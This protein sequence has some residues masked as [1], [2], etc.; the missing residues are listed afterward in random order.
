MFLEK[1]DTLSETLG[2]EYT[3]GRKNIQGQLS[4]KNICHVWE[5][6]GDVFKTTDILSVPFQAH[7]FCP[8]TIVIFLDLTQPKMM[9][10]TLESCVQN[11]K[12]VIEKQGISNRSSADRINEIQNKDGA[13]PLSMIII[14]GKYELFN[15]F[16]K[17]L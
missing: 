7:K 13:F 3:F 12:S 1:D 17:Y 9:W 15:E 11:L 5:L 10:V 6:G 2:L 8:M 16:G 4:E 14:G